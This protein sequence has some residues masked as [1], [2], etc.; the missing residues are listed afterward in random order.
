MTVLISASSVARITGMSHLCLAQS[1]F[2]ETGSHYVPQ[3]GLDFTR[4][5]NSFC[6]LDHLASISKVLGL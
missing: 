2:L 5:P 3:G 1:L 4:W 6:I